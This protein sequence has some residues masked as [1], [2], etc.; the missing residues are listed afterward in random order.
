MPT[1]RCFTFYSSRERPQWRNLENIL[2]CPDT[3]RTFGQ[4]YHSLASTESS[5]HWL[6]WTSGTFSLAWT[7]LNSSTWDSILYILRRALYHNLQCFTLLLNRRLSEIRN[8]FFVS[9]AGFGMLT[10]CEKWFC[11]CIYCSNHKLINQGVSEQCGVRKR[12]FTFI[13]YFVT[14]TP[15][16][17]HI[18]QKPDKHWKHLPW[19]H[20]ILTK[21][22]WS[23]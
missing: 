19:K 3:F 13:W 1:F 8:F 4:L 11:C 22:R 15:K 12:F 10:L 7:G 2:T 9:S 6:D 16:P 20:F 23:I 14:P 17:H 18:W 21:Q 5:L